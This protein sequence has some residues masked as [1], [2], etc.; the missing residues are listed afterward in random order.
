MTI[1]G[2]SASSLGK[3]LQATPS[4]GI[5]HG[6]FTAAVT[7]RL[8][9]KLP[10][11]PCPFRTRITFADIEA[12]TEQPIQR[13]GFLTDCGTQL[14][15]PQDVIILAKVNHLAVW[16]GTEIVTLC[17]DLSRPGRLDMME[18]R[19][20]INRRVYPIIYWENM[21]LRI[22]IMPVGTAHIHDVSSSSV[23]NRHSYAINT[24]NRIYVQAYLFKKGEKL[25][26][27]RQ[28][29]FDRNA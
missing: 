6:T 28:R 8:D 22:V 17:R 23:R 25:D 3:F 10:G 19:H 18:Y 20:V 9:N 12:I 15:A 13:P 2:R 11:C 27:D 5:A 16:V 24:T 4:G 21:L 1:G 14:I 7:C 26:L 29:G